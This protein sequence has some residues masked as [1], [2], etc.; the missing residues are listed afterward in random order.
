MARPLERTSG[1]W[2]RRSRQRD[3]AD[4][5]RSGTQSAAPNPLVQRGIKPHIGLARP[6]IAV[7]HQTLLLQLE[8]GGHLDRAAQAQEYRTSIL[9]QPLDNLLAEFD[10]VEFVAGRDAGHP[11]AAFHTGNGHSVDDRF[12]D[13]GTGADEL[14]DLGGRYV[15]ALPPKAV[16]DPVDKVEVAG[17]IAPHQIAGA[18]PGVPGGKN[19]VK[20]LAVGGRLVGIPFEPAECGRP[21]GGN[22]A[23]RLAGLVRRTAQAEA[24]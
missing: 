19:I 21:V 5:A 14:F 4:Q 1:N 23:D 16:T 13:A 8:G 18:I 9:R 22:S 12:S 20:D 2:S 3:R 11:G 24:L 15:F 17:M 6:V 7:A 10:Q